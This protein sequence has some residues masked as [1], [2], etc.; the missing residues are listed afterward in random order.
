[1]TL[2]GCRARSEERDLRI[3]RNRLGYSADAGSPSSGEDATQ[4]GGAGS[5][6]QAVQCESQTFDIT[7]V[8]RIV[9]VEFNGR[10]VITEREIPGITGG[11]ID[12]EEGSPGPIMLQGD[13]GAIEYR[14]ITIRPAR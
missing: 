8:G 4:R 13:H 6:P 11:A 1:M 3:T 7:L 14:N 12:S 10:R 9:T 2:A 5:N